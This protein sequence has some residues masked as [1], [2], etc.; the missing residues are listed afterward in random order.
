LQE[1]TGCGS[2]SKCELILVGGRRWAR[3]G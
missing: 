3:E 1:G 2:G